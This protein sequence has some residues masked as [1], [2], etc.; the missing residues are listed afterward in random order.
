MLIIDSMLGKLRASIYVALARERQ[1]VAGCDNNRL[2]WTDF[3]C[4]RIKLVGKRRAIAAC[5]VELTFANHVRELDA[6][7]NSLCRSE[8][9]KPQ[10]RPGET[11]D[12]TMILLDDI[13]EILDLPDPDRDVSLRVQLLE[14]CLVGTALVHRYRYGDIVVPHRL[15]EEAPGRCCIAFSGQQEIDGFAL[16]VHGTI[17]LLPGAFDLDVRLIHPPAFTDRV[18]MLPEELVQ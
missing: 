13:I 9:F 4:Q 18:L 7:Q 16:L 12:G 11:F 2:R 6:G 8:R 5:H 3:S 1:S 15:V 14:R 10:H 17:E